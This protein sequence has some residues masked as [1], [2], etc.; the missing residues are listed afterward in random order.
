M[1]IPKFSFARKGTGLASPQEVGF[2]SCDTNI[3]LKG[4][5]R[6]LLTWP[7]QTPADPTGWPQP[8][9]RTVCWAVAKGSVERLPREPKA[10]KSAKPFGGRDL[11]MGVY[12]LLTYFLFLLN[13]HFCTQF[14]IH[15][16]NALLFTNMEGDDQGGYMHYCLCSH[17][18]KERNLILTQNS[19]AI[20]T[21]HY[22]TLR[23]SL[24]EFRNG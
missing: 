8:P 5:F 6:P 24:L 12:D 23:N 1:E 20:A 4:E 11:W 10:K 21:S 2:R 13:I 16:Y 3:H 22:V 18:S 14:C 9:P 7:Q 17:T 19:K 15:N